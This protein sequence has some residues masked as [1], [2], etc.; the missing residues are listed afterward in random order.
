MIMK[1]KSRAFTPEQWVKVKKQTVT[2]N[3]FRT[4]LSTTIDLLPADH[5]KLLRLCARRTMISLAM[6]R[7]LMKQQSG[8]GVVI[9]GADGEK[10]AI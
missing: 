2:Y 9:G 10:V 7:A 6:S 3:L 4:F 8:A 5:M 1:P